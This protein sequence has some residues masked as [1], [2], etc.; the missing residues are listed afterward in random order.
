MLFATTLNYILLAAPVKVVQ[1]IIGIEYI[2]PMSLFFWVV[3]ESI[4]LSTW[5]TTPGKLLLGITVREIDGSKLNFSRAL[6]RS[7]S[8]WF[9]GMGCGI[10]FIEFIT[11]VTSYNRLSKKGITR[12]DQNGKYSISH[13][14]V[15]T[16]NIIIVI[17]IWIGIAALRY[18]KVI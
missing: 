1:I 5:G 12:W 14:K 13:T 6:N 4:L 10:T 8:V 9:Y 3:V 2:I 17:M 7:A 18:F 15:S 16:V 11:K